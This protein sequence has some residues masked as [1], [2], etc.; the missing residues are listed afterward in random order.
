MRHACALA[1]GLSLLAGCAGPG[2]VS[3]PPRPSYPDRPE[4]AASDYYSPSAE[5]AVI[6]FEGVHVAT[7]GST[8]TTGPLN[9]ADAQWEI[10][11]LMPF[12]T[13]PMGAGEVRAGPRH[14]G[15]ATVLSVEVL[16]QGRHRIRYRYR[17]SVAIGRNHGPTFPVHVPRSV[18][19]IYDAGQ[20]P[21]A[22]DAARN[23][24]T[25]AHFNTSQ[26]FWYFWN[27]AKAGCPLREG[28]DYDVYH[29]RVTVVPNLASTR[30]PDYPRL[31]DANG[32]LH[33]YLAFGSDQDAKGQRPPEGN[34]DLNAANALDVSRRLGEQGFRRRR[35]GAAE[36]ADG[37]AAMKGATPTRDEFVR[38]DGDRKV[39]VHTF[40]GSTDPHGTSGGFSCFLDEALRRGGMFTYSAHSGLG[41]AVFLQ[42]LRNESGLPLRPDPDRYQIF[43]FFSCSSYGY[44]ASEFLAAKATAA[45]PS[46]ARNGDVVTSALTTEFEK[47]ARAT[48]TQVEPV[49]RWSREGRWTS[50][51]EIMRA[52]DEGTMVGVNGIRPNPREPY[53]PSARAR[54][55]TAR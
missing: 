37:C 28:V 8:T 1:L 34:D 27:P 4:N 14:D 12:M 50:W 40:W 53:G 31:L 24:C 25:D 18:T 47:L 49:L 20:V 35:L 38:Q 23:P 43:A 48:W 33:L 7:F 55:A 39:V 42:S 13:G 26:Y 41:H 36:T 52:A 44:Y 15:K 3:V 21:G 11:R 19:G 16:G 5:E 17:G 54:I 32:E 10:E 9:V 46:G 29:A 45:D 2:P 6:E 30:Y 51:R 22:T